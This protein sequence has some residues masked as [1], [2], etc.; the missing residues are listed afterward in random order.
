MSVYRRFWSFLLIWNFYDS[1]LAIGCISN[2]SID[3]K[4]FV[5]KLPAK[6]HLWPWDDSDLSLH[7]FLAINH[8]LAWDILVQHWSVIYLLYILSPSLH[9][10]LI[11]SSSLRAQSSIY[12]FIFGST[13][14][15]LLQMGFLWCSEWACLAVVPLVAELSS[16]ALPSAAAARGSVVVLYQLSCPAACGIFLD[17]GSNA[18]PS[19]WQ[20]DS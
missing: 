20:A 1:P 13:G 19:H 2:F 6:N 3:L 5:F 18:Y 11:S 7:L 16:R 4:S 17:Q 12:L 10:C 15:W 14:S 9:L 8:T